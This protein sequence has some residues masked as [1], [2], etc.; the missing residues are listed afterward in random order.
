[1][2]QPDLA[3]LGFKSD[4]MGYVGSDGCHYEDAVSV[5]GGV[6]G[7]CGCGDP[8]AALRYIRDV[9]RLIDEPRP[10]GHVEWEK[11]YEGHRAREVALLPDEGARWLVYY[12]LDDKELTEHGGSVPGWLTG[13]GDD[14]LAALNTMDLDSECAR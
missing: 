14:V 3:S 5:L 13:K 8:E 4:G 10:D 1:M 9:L 6:L 11:W 12:L 7:F 2:N